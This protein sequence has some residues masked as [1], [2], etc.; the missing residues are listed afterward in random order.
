MSSL[1][2]GYNN[3]EYICNIFTEL[4]KLKNKEMKSDNNSSSKWKIKSLKNTLNILQSY[5]KDIVNISD[6]KDIKGIG[7]GGL[8][9]IEE[10]INKGFLE[11]VNCLKNNVDEEKEKLSNEIDKL[12][13]ISG[14]GNVKAKKLLEKNINFDLLMETQKNYDL[15][16][17]KSNEHLKEL[18]KHQFICLKYYDDISQRIP[19]E[20]I[21]IFDNFISEIFS[22]ID[23][24]LIYDIC[25]SFR[26]KNTDS[27][28]IDILFCNKN[29][30]NPD[31]LKDSKKYLKLF[32]KSL[33]NNNIIVEDLTKSGDLKYMGICKVPSYSTNRRLDIKYVPYCSYIPGLLH[34]TGSYKENIRLRQIGKDKGYKINEYGIY[35]IN[36]GKEDLIVLNNEKELY[37]ILG[38]EYKLPENR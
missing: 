34:F 3:R 35:K 2:E 27:G 25:G 28:D 6:I 1:T 15:S 22:N 29:C 18:T 37:D 24:D 32:L 16:N 9:R 14:I 31:D 8:T 33:N 23:K 5:D 4:I 36:D 11:E 13:T 7:K 17:F 30:Q 21:E 38:E 10:I 20:E 26:R 19:R 12:E